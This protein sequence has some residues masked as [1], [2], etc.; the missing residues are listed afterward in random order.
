M[1]I[2]LKQKKERRH[3]IIR[4]LFYIFLMSF[5][6]VFVSVMSTGSALPLLLIPCA[7]CYAVREDFFNS[8]LYGC[9][10]GLL[11]DSASGTLV[12]FNAVLLMW[13]S[14]MIS[15]LFHYYLRRN[16]LN[17]LWLHLVLT[18]ICSFL[19]YLFFYMIWS[20]D[21]S[22]RVLK[23]IFIPELIY[24]NISGI[25]LYWLTGIIKNRFG[26]ITEHYI[27]ERSDNIVRE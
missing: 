1:N 23:E 11:L 14:L 22:G 3:Y 6:Y 18:L 16:I 26:T 20:Y 15:L 7:V 19:H 5:S 17:F 25:F 9:V 4:Q 12:G 27:E 21:L 8:A 10:C 2:E 24:T 13:G